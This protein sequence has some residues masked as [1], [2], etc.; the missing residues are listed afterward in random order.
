MPAEF[1][2]DAVSEAEPVEVAALADLSTGF[3]V[4]ADLLPGRVNIWPIPPSDSPRPPSPR[5][6]HLDLSSFAPPLV[7]SVVRF[8]LGD[9][10]VLTFKPGIPDIV[11]TQPVQLDFR[12]SPTVSFGISWG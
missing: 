8:D 3:A 1:T 9:A 5:P 4:L 6:G 12:I 10:G 2:I 11:G 7:I